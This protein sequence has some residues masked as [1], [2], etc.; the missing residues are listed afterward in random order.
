MPACTWAEIVE[1]FLHGTLSRRDFFRLA[2]TAGVSAGAAS[3]VARQIDAQDA[4]PGAGPA[5][6]EV[7]SLGT[8][9]PGG[10]SMNREEFTRLI[11]ESFEL[12]E[13]GVAGGQVIYGETVDIDS[14]NPHLYIDIYSGYVNGAIYE[15]LAT[16][17]PTNGM[18]APG[19]ADYWEL[20]EDGVTYTFHL[21][22]NARWHDG[23][24]VT[25]EDVV[26]SFDST[27]DENGLSV[28]RSSVDLSLA[29]YR[30][31]DAHTVELVARDRLAVFIQNTAALVGIVPKHLW[32]GIPP[33]EWGSDPGSTGMDPSRVVGSGPFRFVEWVQNDHVTLVRN[34]D[35]W[36]PDG[37]PTIDEFIYRI[38]PEAAG[39]TAALITAEIDL[40]TVPFGEA[41]SLK[42]DPELVIHAFDTTDF[43]VC[44]MNQDPERTELF[45]DTRV[46]QA[47]M[48]ALDRELIAE[49]IY[50]GYASQANGTQPQLSIA[51]D[52]DRINTVYDYDPDRAR[53]LLEEAG[54]VDEDRDG[55]REKDGVRF[56]FEC[57]Y[58]EGIATYEQQL[59]YMQ[60]AWRE[61]GLDMVPVAVPLQVLADAG[62]TGDYDVRVYGFTWSVDGEQ[63]DMFRC[64][65]VPLAGFNAMKYC[66][67]R[68]DELDALQKRELDAEQR[69][70]ILIEQSNIVN[71]EVAAGV[72]LFRQSVVGSR[73]TLHNFL[74]NGYSF[75]WSMQWW[76]TEIQQ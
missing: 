48:Y 9:E 66:N 74:P 2:A 61:V 72:L 49:R 20:A 53:R 42:D 52:P 41:D 60:Q 70:E 13:P 19:L 7:S 38:I 28:N 11:H 44:D 68:Y 14:L 69:I 67:Q 36:N 27:L 4:S 26:F 15:Y 75:L 76:W 31:V 37:M 1:G 6:G 46:R 43:N 51:Y 18:P 12:S 24:P 73:R 34:E 58:S 57:M 33:G 25:A 45:L 47:M 17:N 71:D 8:A 64:D 54:W 62:D 56:S 50:L 23:E 16:T 63:G 40:A 29:S 35:Y 55:I 22:P 3:L 21:H 10:R 5:A 30:A 65:A 32:D 59:P 39:A